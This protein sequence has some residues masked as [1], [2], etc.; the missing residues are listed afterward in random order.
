MKPHL[1]FTLIFSLFISSFTFSKPLDLFFS[2]ADSFLKKWV[3]DGNINY[4]KLKQNFNEIEQLQKQIA[5]ADLNGVS[6]SERKAF[7]INAYNL[8]VIYQI[9]KYYPIKSALDKSGFFDKFNHKVAGET[10]T[11]DRI[12]KKY[13]ILKYH[14]PRIHFAVSCAAVS[15]PKL[16]SFAFK[17]ANL[18]EQLNTRTQLALNK[19]Y[20]ININ[21]KQKEVNVSKIFDWY[22][23]DFGGKVSTTL[24]FINQYRKAKIPNEYNLNYMDYDW[25]LNE[26]K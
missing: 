5:N 26:V 17:P 16:A 9:T 23:V 10:I 20:V 24:E 15:C 6:E 7:Y 2:E 14:D 3:N 22:K 11:L 19:D 1:L 21:N 25:N 8:L 12:E 4:N 13:L 18:E